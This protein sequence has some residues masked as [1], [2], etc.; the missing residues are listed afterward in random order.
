MPVSDLAT[1]IKFTAPLNDA[2]DQEEEEQQI[3]TRNI[4]ID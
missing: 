4:I 2:S 3:E 1:K